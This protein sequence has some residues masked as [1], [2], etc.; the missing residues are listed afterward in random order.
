MRKVLMI[1]D[2]LE[3]IN[4]ILKTP[5]NISSLWYIRALPIYAGQQLQVMSDLIHNNYRGHAR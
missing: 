2:T 1:C 3:S 5:Y 4:K